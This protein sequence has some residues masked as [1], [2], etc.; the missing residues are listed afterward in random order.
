MKKQLI[1]IGLTLVLL[2]VGLNGCT[3]N[4][5]SNFKITGTAVLPE[6]DVT[7]SNNLSGGGLRGIYLCDLSLNVIAS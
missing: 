3:T 1:I 4:K 5:K 6:L 2:T 7:Y